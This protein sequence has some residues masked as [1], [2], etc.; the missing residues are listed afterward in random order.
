[1]GTLGGGVH[2]GELWQRHPGSG[3][4]M[5]GPQGARP[6]SGDQRRVVSAHRFWDVP[7]SLGKE[8]TS[9]TQFNKEKPS[10]LGVC[11]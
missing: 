4:S 2:T 9:P 1:M 8:G 6:G 7:S 10:C 5:P 11:V 3:L